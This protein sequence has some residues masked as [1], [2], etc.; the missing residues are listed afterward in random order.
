MDE[1][2]LRIGICEIL[3]PCK[4]TRLTLSYQFISQPLLLINDFN[5]RFIDPS[6]YPSINFCPVICGRVKE[7]TLLSLLGFLFQ[8]QSGG[9]SS[10]GVLDRCLNPL[11]C[12]RSTPTCSLG[13]NELIALPPGATLWRWNRFQQLASVM[14]VSPSAPRARGCRWKLEI[15]PAGRLRSLLSARTS[16]APRRSAATPP[17]PLDIYWFFFYYPH[18]TI[19]LHQ[20][21]H[22]ES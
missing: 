14:P 12:L 9:R 11:G 2:E 20:M 21:K 15:K 7:H 18:Y 10:E 4:V 13:I 6:L 3:L 8:L 19:T 22:K 17:P 16:S 5:Y 1:R